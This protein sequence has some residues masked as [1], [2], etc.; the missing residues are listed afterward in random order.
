MRVVRNIFP[1]VKGVGVSTSSDRS[2]CAVCLLISVSVVAS[3]CAV[4]VAYN[5]FDTTGTVGLMFP[6]R[7]PERLLTLKSGSDSPEGDLWAYATFWSY[8]PK[9]ENG[10]GSDGEDRITKFAPR[11]LLEN[12][13]KT[14]KPLSLQPFERLPNHCKEKIPSLEAHQNQELYDPKKN[15]ME[16]PN[17]LEPF[18]SPLF[19]ADLSKEF[20][21]R[22]QISKAAHNLMFKA[23]HVMQQRKQPFD[24]RIPIY[25]S[26]STP[27][28]EQFLAPN[29]EAD[30]RAAQ[31]ETIEAAMADYRNSTK[32]LFIVMGDHS[33]LHG[34]R[35]EDVVRVRKLPD[36]VAL[37]VMSSGDGAIFNHGLLPT[38]GALLARANVTSHAMNK[39]I[40]DAANNASLNWKASVV[41]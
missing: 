36:S 20:R 32:P 4:L 10:Q 41:F 1:N 9:D 6:E 27:E 39:T 29:G 17:D 21:F 8:S 14:F 23:E 35:A 13:E 11:R 16:F 28:M 24:T 26:P 40:I 2:P 25:L 37:A 15:V 12:L 33:L 19:A 3:V 22:N 30:A 31:R 5:Y 7:C 18:A 34:V 38:F